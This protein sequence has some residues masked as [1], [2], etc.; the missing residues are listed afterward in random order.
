MYT[1]YNLEDPHVLMSGPLFLVYAEQIDMFKKKLDKQLPI[2]KVR[3]S[4]IIEF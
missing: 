4:E 3:V 2:P 1:K